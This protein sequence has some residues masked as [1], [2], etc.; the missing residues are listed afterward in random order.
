[1]QNVASWLLLAPVILMAL[2]VFVFCFEIIAAVVL[3]QPRFSEKAVTQKRPRI[4]VLI[5]AH[6]EGEGLRPTVENVKSQLREGDRLLVVA[7]NCTDDTSSVAALLGAEVIDRQ[8]PLHIG[9]GY[10]LDFGI[11]HLDCD[12]PQVLIIVDADCIFAE[13]SIDT[14][15]AVCR[16]ERRPVQALN[17]MKAPDGFPETFELA[18]F[19]WRVKNWARPLGLRALRMPCQLSGTGM[20][21]PWEIIRSVRLASGEIVE[22]LKLGLELAKAGTPAVFC[23]SASVVSYFPTS[24]EGIDSQRE[25]WQKGHLNMI[26]RLAPRMLRD[27]IIKRD[28]RLVTLALDLT[29]PPLFLLVLLEAGLL[30]ASIIALWLGD[31]GLSFYIALAT[32]GLC[33]LA[34]AF[35]WINFGRDVMR[36]KTLLTAP[37]LLGKKLWFYQRIVFGRAVAHHWIR[38]DR[39]KSKP[40]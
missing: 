38:T 8:D 34:I 24:Q 23:P 9:K 28:I 30:S 39:S 7:D 21:F 11:K 5:P 37:L 31:A 15:A 6:N 10:A 40:P 27:G 18:E 33:A 4:G 3:P 2:P 35:C 17:L 12:P 16:A 25:R 36:S 26:A 22:D 20:A 14:L 32:N 19:A 1:M 29:V 13:E